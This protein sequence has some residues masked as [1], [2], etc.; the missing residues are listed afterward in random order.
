M[1]DAGVRVVFAVRLKAWTMP[2][3]MAQA[4]P[5]VVYINWTGIEKEIRKLF[6]TRV[7]SS[8]MSGPYQNEK[9]SSVKL[10]IYANYFMIVLTSL[11]LRVDDFVNVLYVRY[12]Q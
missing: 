12:Y 9:K 4:C 6:Q 2:V 8:L 10:Q 11:I 5:H 1:L 7:Q 3:L